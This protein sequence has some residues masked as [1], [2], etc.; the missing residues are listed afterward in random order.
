MLKVSES[1]RRLTRHHLYFSTAKVLAFINPNQAPPLFRCINIIRL[2][3]DWE[4]VEDCHASHDMFMTR[5]FVLKM[6]LN[7]KVIQT[8]IVSND[9]AQLLNPSCTHIL[10]NR[11]IN[12]GWIHPSMLCFHGFYN[13]INAVPDKKPSTVSRALL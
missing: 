12:R 6:L 9:R 4:G 13:T 5:V 2:M 7:G 10:N 11:L 3:T 1:L 8:F